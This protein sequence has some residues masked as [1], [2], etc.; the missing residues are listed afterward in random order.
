MI[1]RSQGAKIFFSDV[2]DS[3]KIISAMSQT[4][5]KNTERYM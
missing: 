3:A 5:Q 2:S 1:L 4:M